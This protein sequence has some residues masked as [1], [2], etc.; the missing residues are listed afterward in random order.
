[1]SIFCDCMKGVKWY[2]TQCDDQYEDKLVSI[3]FATI[4][5]LENC[6]F[7][8]YCIYSSVNDMQGMQIC[9]LGE[10]IHCGLLITRMA[11]LLRISALRST[12]THSFG[13]G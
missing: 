13:W 3:W 10:N 4:I 1:M 11:L 9:V 7:L 6:I 12:H 5:K 8:Y 2:T